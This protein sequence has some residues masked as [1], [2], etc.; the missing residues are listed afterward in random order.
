M[1]DEQQNAFVVAAFE[2]LDSCPCVVAAAAVGSAVD[3][4]YQHFAEIF[5][6]AVELVMLAADWDNGKFVVVA[7]AAVDDVVPVVVESFVD[8]VVNSFAAD[9]AAAA[10]V[11]LF[12]VQQI[13]VL[14]GILVVHPGK[15]KLDAVALHR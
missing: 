14:V 1:E 7:A 10:V 13:V 3:F 11:A 15:H 12:F 2:R 4:A 8:S 5:A 9:S 6:A